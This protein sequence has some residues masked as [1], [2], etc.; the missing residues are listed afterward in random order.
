MDP[1][2]S[3]AE[4][5]RRANHVPQSRVQFRRRSAR[6]Y[7]DRIAMRDGLRG[8]TYR[9]FQARCGRLSA[10]LAPRG[11]RRGDTV[12]ILAPDV[13]AM[14]GKRTTRFRHWARVPSCL[15]RCQKH[16]RERFRSSRCVSRP[17]I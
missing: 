7:P 10:A 17:R 5:G 8:Y 6:I 16:P 3:D 11:I 9:E 2:A 13:P 15:V 1:A 12:A 4:A 14:P